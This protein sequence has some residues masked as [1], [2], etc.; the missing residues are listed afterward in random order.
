MGKCKNSKRCSCKSDLGERIK[1][2]A[3]LLK[4]LSEAGQ[5]ESAVIIR[6][7]PHCFIR[8]LCECVLNILKGKLELKPNQYKKLRPHKRLLL[9]LSEPSLPLTERREVLLKKKGGALPGLIPILLSGL[10]G[11]AADLIG[12]LF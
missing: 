8:F 6:K 3:P 1:E 11:I 10:T 9:K 5:R 7:A 4:I 12:K 2:H